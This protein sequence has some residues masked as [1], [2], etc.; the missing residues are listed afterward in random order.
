MPNFNVALTQ[1][2]QYFLEESSSSSSSPGCSL[3][4]L[5]V[6]AL[7]YLPSTRL[8][9]VGLGP[10]LD[11]TQQQ[12][13]SQSVMD[14]VW[15]N[16][17][18]CWNEWLT[19]SPFFPGKPGACVN[20][21]VKTNQHWQRHSFRKLKERSVFTG[22]HYFI[23]WLTLLPGSPRAPS[24]PWEQTGSLGFT[25]LLG[26]SFHPIMRRTEMESRSHWPAASHIIT[27]NG[28]SLTFSPGG[29]LGPAK[30]WR[31]MQRDVR[32]TICNIHAAKYQTK[33]AHG[34]R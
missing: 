6:P 14:G 23:W 4:L 17:K 15:V 32:R 16:R 1:I 9:P 7:L 2:I 34:C 13:G 21:S 26:N 30:P 12:R 28:I 11:K 19:W 5:A 8:N 24:L 25:S 31:E 18:L 33:K 10:P 22:L 3:S 27:P 29:P 20:N